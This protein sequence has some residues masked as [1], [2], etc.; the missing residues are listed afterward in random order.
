LEN[1]LHE[2]CFLFHVEAIYLKE[3]REKKK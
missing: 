2:C 1:R 3:Y